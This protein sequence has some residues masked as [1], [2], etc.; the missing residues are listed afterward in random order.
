[1]IGVRMR[2]DKK[3]DPVNA[4]RA[5]IAY[6]PISLVPFTGINKD[7][8]VTKDNERGIPL[9]HIKKVHGEIS[10]I[11]TCMGRGATGKRGTQTIEA[12]GAEQAGNHENDETTGDCKRGT[13][14]VR[15]PDG[16]CHK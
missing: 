5:E 10:I 13:M 8:R 15:L 3:I 9:P 6:D 2:S 7:G 4:E 14:L 16:L 12:P 1:M 11:L